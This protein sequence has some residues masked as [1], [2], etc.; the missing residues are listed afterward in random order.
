MVYNMGLQN[1]SSEAQ[2]VNIFLSGDHVVSVITTGSVSVQKQPQRVSGRAWWVPINFYSW[3]LEFHVIFT[4][5]KNVL[6]LNF[7]QP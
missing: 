5:H 3:M 1:L 6:L 7:F 4:C 2:R